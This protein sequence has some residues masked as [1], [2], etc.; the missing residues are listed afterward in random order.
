M[1]RIILLELCF[2]FLATTFQGDNPPPGWYLQSIPVNKNITDIHF[3]DT[4]HGWAVTGNLGAQDSGYILK[5]TNGGTNWLLNYA[6]NRNFFGIQF[7]DTNI[8]YASGGWGTGKLYKTTNGGNNWNL[9]LSGGIYLTDLH[10][11]NKDTGWVCD[12]DGFVGI[13]LLK[14][15][16]G[17]NNWVQQLNNSY[18]PKKLFFLNNDTGWVMGY[19]G[20]IYR[21]TNS[22]VNWASVYNFGVVNMYSIFFT[23]LDTG[24]VIESGGIHKTINGGYN[25]TVQQDPYSQGSGPQNIY[26]INST[27]G[28]ITTAF[29]KIIKTTNGINWGQQN[30]PAGGYSSIYLTDSLIGWAN[31]GNVGNNDIAAT[32]DGGG[33]VVGVNI[34]TTEVPKEYILGQ[35]Y[36][37]PFNQSSIINYQLSIDG[38]ISIKIYDIS[39]KEISTL[40]NERKSAGKYS[41][42][43]NGN[44]L[45]SGIYFYSLYA[46]GKM[47]ETKRMTLLK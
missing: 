21:T 46:D 14:T 26:M 1:K 22:G 9:I 11:L 33:P 31:H 42:S 15:T 23:S 36:P 3:T 34:I 17:G 35:N 4:L 18:Q 41:V 5:T 6:T 2:L 10:F 30:A 20:G 40:I 47:I 25:W 8:G 29:F 24:W 28:Y 16:N 37:N 12:Y 32:Q 39:G 45:S 44:S 38:M 7:L 19:S 27:Y 13:G 43:F